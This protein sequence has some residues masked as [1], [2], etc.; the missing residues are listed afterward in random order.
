LIACEWL[1]SRSWHRYLHRKTPQKSAWKWGI[2]TWVSPRVK[3]TLPWARGR[4]PHI[5]WICRMSVAPRPSLLTFFCTYRKY[6][7]SHPL[8]D[9]VILLMWWKRLLPSGSSVIGHKPKSNLGWNY[10]SR[11]PVSLSELPVLSI[12]FSILHRTGWKSLKNTKQKKTSSRIHPF[13]KRPSML[14]EA[15][16]ILHNA[17][18]ITHYFL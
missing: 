12:C 10:S 13:D 3:S 5:L 2:V 11:L 16:M 4:R 1:L 7:C 17:L 9:A 6:T 14:G 15:S 8:C 18:F